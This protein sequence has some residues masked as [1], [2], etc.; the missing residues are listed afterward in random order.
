MRRGRLRAA[1]LLD[2]LPTI[3]AFLPNVADLGAGEGQ[4]LALASGR[5]R[6]LQGRPRR[7]YIRFET[8]TLRAALV[9]LRPHEASGAG[10]AVCGVVLE[11]VEGRVSGFPELVEDFALF[12]GH[13]G[14][15]HTPDAMFHSTGDGTWTAQT[16]GVV[17]AIYGIWAAARRTSTRPA[18]TNRWGTVLYSTGDG[19]WTLQA[20]VNANL[21]MIWGS[22]PKDLDAIGVGEI[23]TTFTGYISRSPGDYTWS[24][25]VLNPDPGTGNIWGSSA[26]DVYIVGG[27][28]FVLH[29][30]GDG[31][32]T[33]EST[34]Q[35]NAGAS[36]VYAIGAAAPT[37][38]TWA[39][40]EARSCATPG[41]ASGRRRPG[42]AWWAAS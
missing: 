35:P 17:Q 16:T 40:T 38:S 15:H 22:G 32:W 10:G 29:S 5:G 9:R 23:G 8:L 26:T 14:R 11:V 37:T 25:Q 28:G 33:S 41:T 12:G 34:G 19:S 36:D 21:A 24:G 20:T 4:V 31:T 18:E 30:T 27:P 7:R 42:R 3:A 1:R 13:S 2:L 6:L 39:V